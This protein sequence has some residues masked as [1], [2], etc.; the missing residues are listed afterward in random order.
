MWAVDC[1]TLQLEYDGETLFWVT[2]GRVHQ[3]D[4]RRTH[5][6]IILMLIPGSIICITRH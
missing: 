2:S 5:L 6:T 3:V 1:G 4:E